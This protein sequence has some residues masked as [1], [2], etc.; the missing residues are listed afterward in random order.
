MHLPDKQDKR[1]NAESGAEVW[2]S[3][4][5]EKCHPIVGRDAGVAPWCIALHGRGSSLLNLAYTHNEGTII[6]SALERQNR[7]NRSG[8]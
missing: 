8:I 7:A 4:I 6:R 3:C 2:R 5:K 1:R